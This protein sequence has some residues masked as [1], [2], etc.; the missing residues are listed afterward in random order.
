MKFVKKNTVVFFRYIMK[1]SKGQVVENAMEGAPKYYLHGSS[2]I[3][4]LLQCQM[5]GLTIGDVRVIYLEKKIT[6]S[7]DDFSFQI[8]I[9][10][11]RPAL[12]E[13]LMLGYPVVIDYLICD[14]QCICYSAE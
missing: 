1:N 6:L 13:E 9:D 3:H 2:G 7:N 8:I 10:G 4:H 11:L 5:E 14:S 12:E